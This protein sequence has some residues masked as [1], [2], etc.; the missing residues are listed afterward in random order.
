MK[1]CDFRMPFHS[2]EEEER[3]EG[4]RKEVE[5]RYLPCSWETHRE[6]ELLSSCHSSLEMRARLTSLIFLMPRPP[7]AF[8]V[9]MESHAFRERF[10]VFLGGKPH[11]KFLKDLSNS[12]QQL[13]GIKKVPM[14]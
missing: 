13:F 14:A 7:M 1:D 6:S 8:G 3:G 9:Q 5:F 10:L 2:Q 12:L 4:E 11:R